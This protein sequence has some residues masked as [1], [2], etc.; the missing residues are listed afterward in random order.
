[1]ER[2]RLARLRRAIKRKEFAVSR[3]LRAHVQGNARHPV[4][5][6]LSHSGGFAAL[7]LADTALRIGVDLEVHRPRDVLATARTAFSEFEARALEDAAHPERERLFY[8]MWTVKEA[9]AK[10]LQLHLLEALR[11]CVLLVD[12]SQW[13]VRAPTVSAGCVAVY[14]PR[15]DVTL[16]IAS[17]GESPAIECWSWPPQ[18]LA[19]WPLIAAIS[20][21]GAAAPAATDRESAAAARAAA[22]A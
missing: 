16:A 19:S 7:A 3:A 4:S 12:G 8:A 18:Q 22:P 9:L 14:Q 17:I 11:S 6:S 13:Q 2:V 15:A 5:E 20:L 10:A 21:A 1:M